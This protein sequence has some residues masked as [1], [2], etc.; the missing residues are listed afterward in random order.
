MLVRAAQHLDTR[1]VLVILARST[2]QGTS[3]A[4][5]SALLLVCRPL[6]TVGRRLGLHRY[7]PLDRHMAYHQAC[8]VVGAGLG[9]VHS[10]CHLAQLAR[11]WRSSP[12]SLVSWLFTPIPGKATSKTSMERITD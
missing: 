2:G 4:L 1:Q 3:L 5:A 7:L 6:I 9:L 11:T 12:H 8:G 10:G